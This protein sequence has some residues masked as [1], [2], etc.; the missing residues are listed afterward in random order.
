LRVD[1][2]VNHHQRRLRSRKPRFQIT[3]REKDENKG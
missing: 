3:L 2:V 1:Q